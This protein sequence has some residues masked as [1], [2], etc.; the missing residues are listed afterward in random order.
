MQV[1]IP[2]CYPQSCLSGDV[3]TH[4]HT[5]T[6]LNAGCCSHQ[7]PRHHVLCLSPADGTAAASGVHLQVGHDLAFFMC[8]VRQQYSH[9]A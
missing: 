9:E 6:C 7:P 1:A 2:A 4:T 5:H 8:A 3:R